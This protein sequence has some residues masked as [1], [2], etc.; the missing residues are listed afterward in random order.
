MKY[1]GAHV[2]AEGGLANTTRSSFEL[3]AQAFCFFTK[4]LTNWF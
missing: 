4:H 3:R 2:S 1:I